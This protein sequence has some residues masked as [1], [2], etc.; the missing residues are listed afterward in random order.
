[1]SER[2]H[3]ARAGR[4]FKRLPFSVEDVAYA[5]EEIHHGRTVVPPHESL[6]KAQLQRWDS[7]LPLSYSNVA[8]FSR[9]QA[10]IHEKE[11]LEGGKSPAEVWGAQALKMMRLRQAE[12]RRMAYLR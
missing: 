8:L 9:D 6:S 3:S 11:V 5:F 12:E 10:K 1:M 4:E 7:T 2:R